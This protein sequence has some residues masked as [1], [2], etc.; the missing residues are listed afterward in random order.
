L[1]GIETRL[2]GLMGQAL[3]GDTVAYGQLLS[4]LA[5]H[6]RAFFR[7]RLSRDLDSVED[8]V[9]E[10]LLAVHNQRHTYEPSVPFTPWV[11]AIAKYKLIDY[12]RRNAA[13]PTEPLPADDSLDGLEDSAHD[14]ATARRDIGKLLAALPPHFRLPIQHVKLEGLSVQEAATR[15][16][17]SV[18]AIKIGIHRGLKALARNLQ[19]LADAH[20]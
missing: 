15:T 6:L 13:R 20:G 8:L 14:A 18:S 2:K 5:A 17:M 11:H 9:Q 19:G 1:E 16:G 3:T 10:T 12:L 4:A 7:R